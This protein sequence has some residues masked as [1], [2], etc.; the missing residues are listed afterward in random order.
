LKLNAP[1]LRSWIVKEIDKGNVQQI[2]RGL[3]RMKRNRRD[4]AV[5]WA[6]VANL[7][8]LHNFKVFALKIKRG[9]LAL[10]DQQ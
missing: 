10:L 4:G 5:C 1:T 6:W 7:I 3:Y 8:L 9:T 2:G